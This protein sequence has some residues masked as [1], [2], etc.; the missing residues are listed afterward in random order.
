[1]AAEIVTK[2][3]LPGIILA[4]IGGILLIVQNPMVMKASSD[5]PLAGPGPWLHIKLTLVLVL[6]V[7]VHLKMFRSRKAVRQRSSGEPESDCD[8]LTGK[9]V[10]FGKICQSL[11]GVIFVLATFRYVIFRG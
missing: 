9:A 1:M 4:V 6:L 2:I 3:E 8:A 5:A 7:I 10:L 11:Y